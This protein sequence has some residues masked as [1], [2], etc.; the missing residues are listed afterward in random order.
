MLLSFLQNTGLG[1]RN[2]L[3]QS[4]LDKM[5]RRTPFSSFLNYVAYDQETEIYSRVVGY[6]RP[7]KQ[8]N[9]GKQAEF[10]MRIKRKAC[11]N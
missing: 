10:N 8:W 5:T 7:I 6:L 11:R 4:D 2:H 9:P 3:K 1:G